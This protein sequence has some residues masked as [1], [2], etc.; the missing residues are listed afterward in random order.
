[1]GY[2][3]YINYLASME[4]HGGVLVRDTHDGPV[5]HIVFARP[6]TPKNTQILASI[7]VFT[8]GSIFPDHSSIDAVIDEGFAKIGNLEERYQR[9]TPTKN[10][11]FELMWRPGYPCDASS[12]KQAIHEITSKFE[13]PGPTTSV[14]CGR[15]STLYRYDER[16]YLEKALKLG[17]FRL[18]NA[19]SYGDR[20]HDIA[21]QDDELC[22]VSE[23]E[24]SSFIVTTPAGLVLQP[25]GPVKFVSK[26]AS[27][28]YILCLSMGFSRAIADQFGSEACLK[29]RDPDKFAERLHGAAAKSILGCEGT[30]A[31][32]SYDTKTKSG[33]C[34]TKPIRFATQMEY[35]FAWF[36][37]TAP[38]K[39]LDE[40]FVE[41]GSIEDI[42]EIV[43]LP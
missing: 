17:G 29:I 5:T 15:P 18:A 39:K 9:G 3:I 36:A 30:D 1:M 23:H 24:S 43:N 35:R 28:Y 37:K 7:S 16:V 40:I 34:F 22:R 21:R 10:G 6:Q 14:T 11:Y 12:V 25:S 38:V 31:Q 20:D 42:A 2:D 33:V 27:D 13:H 41:I 32:V 26:L 4:P 8:N 19:A